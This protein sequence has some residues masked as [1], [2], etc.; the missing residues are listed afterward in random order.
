VTDLVAIRPEQSGDETAIHDLVE[1]AFAPMPFSDGDEQDLVD[2]LREKGELS[3]SLVAIDAAGCLVGH[4]GFSP[5][6][7][8]GLDCGWQQ[9]APVAV[10][11]ALQGAGIGSM[12]IRTGIE[13]LR[14]AG[15]RGIGVVGNPA[16]YERFGFER[17]ENIVPPEH[18]QPYFR[19]LV[20]QGDPPEG[21]LRYAS[22]FG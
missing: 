10:E 8:A 3:L 1:R 13:M 12:L 4:V 6:T 15:T 19:A 17:C 2:L 18:D 16:Y 9:M 20:L 14:T 11:P 7:I 21:N 22:A 5:V